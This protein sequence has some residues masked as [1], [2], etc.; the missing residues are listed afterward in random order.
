MVRRSLKSLDETDAFA[1]ELADQLHPGS[2][3]C[4]FGDLGAGKTTLIKSLI[5]YLGSVPRNEVTSPTF[6]YCI[7]YN[8]LHHFDLYRLSNEKQFYALGF[9]E[10][11]SPDA[12]CFI[13]W[14]ERI[15]N[16]I[17]E[18]A[19]RISMEVKGPNERFIEYE[20]PT[21]CKS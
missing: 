2:I 11:F 14:S 16:I 9:E 1:K 10:Y 7:S 18:H 8:H 5:H 17:P 4:F 6:N 15:K 20:A 13:E 3:V 21:L 12:I 19:I